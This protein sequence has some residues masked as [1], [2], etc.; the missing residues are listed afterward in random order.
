MAHIPTSQIEAIHNALAE[1]IR[2]KIIRLLLDRELCVCELVGALE[3][4]Q[5]KVSRHLAILK[6]AG[7]VQDRRSGTWIFYS[8]DSSLSAEWLGVLV[9]L[10]KVWDYNNEV[11]QVLHRM[12]TIKFRPE[13]QSCSDIF[14][15]KENMQNDAI[16]GE[17]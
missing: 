5:Y 16:I 8:I 7:L 6:S 1:F 9:E 17:K 14:N 2:I 12:N 11:Q 13:T 3:E 10:S 4:P 15:S